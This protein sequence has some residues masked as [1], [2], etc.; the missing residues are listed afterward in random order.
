[1]GREVVTKADAAN[2]QN[3]YRELSTLKQQL[4][5][6]ASTDP[7]PPVTEDKY[8]DRLLKYI[9]AD[10]IAIYLTLHSFV[11]MLPDEAP[12]KVVYW[13]VFVVILLISIPWQRKIAKIKKWPQVWIGTVA[14]FIWALSVGHPFTH[15]DFSWYYSVY[16]S[17]ILALYTFMIP[18][19]EIE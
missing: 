10:V 12:K 13:I 16:G 18:L 6:V 9:P 4:G 8:K 5:L 7:V 19:F 2:I 14:F 15:E 11:P 17:M 1:M 3:A